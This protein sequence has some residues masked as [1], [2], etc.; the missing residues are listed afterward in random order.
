[1]KPRR[2]HFRKDPAWIARCDRVSEMQ[3]A[4]S[5][6]VRAAVAFEMACAENKKRNTIGAERA[7]DAALEELGVRTRRYMRLIK[8]RKSR[9]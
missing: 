8:K 5:A 1:M 7:V 4:K 9:G 3:Y 6:L 2:L